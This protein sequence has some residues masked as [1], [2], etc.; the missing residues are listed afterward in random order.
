MCVCVC[1][2]ERERESS[3]IQQPN[4][5]IVCASRADILEQILLLVWCA[6]LHVWV[7]TATDVDRGEYVCVIPPELEQFIILSTKTV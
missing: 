3:F 1:E 4:L 6:A 2:R 5:V 7:S